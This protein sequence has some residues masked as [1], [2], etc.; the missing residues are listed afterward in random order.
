MPHKAGNK[1][2]MLWVPSDLH[3]A[4]KEKLARTG[5][6]LRDLIIWFLEKWTGHKVEINDATG[7]TASLESE[8]K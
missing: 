8:S 3:A 2:V 6:S 1:S 4:M 5:I 7:K